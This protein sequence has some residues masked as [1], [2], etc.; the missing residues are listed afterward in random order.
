MKM[1][2]YIGIIGILLTLVVI[3]PAIAISPV[4]TTVQSDSH[5]AALSHTNSLETCN[6]PKGSI[7]T[8]GKNNLSSAALIKP[9]DGK[10]SWLVN[11]Y[12]PIL[13][14]TQNNNFAAFFQPATIKTTTYKESDNGNTVAA[15]KGQVV[16]IQLAENPTTGY[17]WEPSVSSGIQITDDTYT[18][19]NTRAVGSGGIRTW[20]LRLNGT[21]GQYFNAEYKR[22]WESGSVDNYS[23]HFVVS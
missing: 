1:M 7:G 23:I 6:L 17:R 8:N 3:C 11:T 14:V 12:R 19:S 5:G 13:P 18:R 10:F 20:T 16:K 9:G 2:V 15:Q 4:T 22:S 21:G